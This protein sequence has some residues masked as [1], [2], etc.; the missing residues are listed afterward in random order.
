MDTF[1]IPFFSDPYFSIPFRYSGFCG[2]FSRYYFDTFFVAWY[3]S[4]P[5][6]YFSIPFRYFSDTF[7][8]CIQ[9]AF[10][11]GTLRDTFPCVFKFVSI[12]SETPFLH[13]AHLGLV[14]DTLLGR[15]SH[16]SCLLLAPPAHFWP[17]LAP[18]CSSWLFLAPHG[19]SW[20]PSAPPGSSRLLL[21]PP[22]SPFIPC[23]GVNFEDS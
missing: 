23:V 21:A 9:S 18:P 17:L 11:V 1:S 8:K 13:S 14:H 7:S 15:P 12:G 20:L 22:G 2:S 10:I 4:I 3:F 16:S 19:S 5:F 6:S